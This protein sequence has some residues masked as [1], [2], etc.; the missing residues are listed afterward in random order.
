[1]NNNAYHILQMINGG[2]NPQQVMKQILSMNVNPQEIERVILAQN[3]QLQILANQM[4]QSGL[5]P[6]QFVMQMAKQNNIPIQ[7]NVLNNT[8]NEMLNMA[9]SKR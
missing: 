8:Y 1:M 2:A 7:E 3:P 5:S 6:M 9:N 4:K